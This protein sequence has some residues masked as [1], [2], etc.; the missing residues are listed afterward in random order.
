MD[1]VQDD[2]EGLRGRRGQ[3]GRDRAAEGKR[4]SGHEA[5]RRP[6]VDAQPLHQACA[7]IRFVCKKIFKLVFLVVV[8]AVVVVG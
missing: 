7:N 8:L 2:G 5:G 6:Q 3:S 4:N 1:H